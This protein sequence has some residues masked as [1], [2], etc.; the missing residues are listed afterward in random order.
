MVK[1]GQT[2]RV[3]PGLYIININKLPNFKSTFCKT[4]EKSLENF[5]S[6]RDN[7]SCKS[8]SGMTKFDLGMYY[9]KTNSCTRLHVTLGRNI[10][11]VHSLY[12]F[13]ASRRDKYL[14][15]QCS[16]SI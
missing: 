12:I 11:N 10:T 16:M 9:V 14:Y 15:S 2:R 13:Y 4:A 5:I 3:G 7:I 6:A 1:V 8:E